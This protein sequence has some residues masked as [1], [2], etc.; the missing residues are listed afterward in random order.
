MVVEV[1]F[2]V[3]VPDAVDVLNVPG[4]MDIVITVLVTF[5]ESVDVTPGSVPVG[6]AV[7]VLMIGGRNAGL[8]SRD[9]SVLNEDGA[10]WFKYSVLI[11][12]ADR[13]VFEMRTSSSVPARAFD[14]LEYAPNPFT[15]EYVVG[16]V[17]VPVALT[18]PST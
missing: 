15:P 6:D 18:T 7:K 10:F 17:T 9:P 8:V 11:Q 2:T 4:V 14:P 1:G 3:V 13:L 12:S 5:Q 16:P